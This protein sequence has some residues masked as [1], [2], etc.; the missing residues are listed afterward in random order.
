MRQYSTIFNLLLGSLFLLLNTACEREGEDLIPAT[1]PGKRIEFTVSE[2]EEDPLRTELAED[3]KTM[4]WTSGDR[5]GVFY[6]TQ[7]Q[8]GSN[9]VQK[10][11]IPYSLVETSEEGKVGRFSGDIAWVDVTGTHKFQLYYPYNEQ[12]TSS[13]AAYGT[14]P[15]EQEYSPTEWDLSKYAFMVSGTA[16]TTEKGSNPTI[17]LRHLFSILRLEFTNATGED[18]QIEKVTLTSTEGLILAGD[19]QANIGK[20]NTL[21]ALHNATEVSNTDGRFTSPSSSVS[22]LV[23]D[24]VVKAGE[25]I[26]IRLMIN[27]GLKEDSKDEYYLQ[28]AKLRVEVQTKGHPL[29]STEFT[30]GKLARGARAAK[31]LTIDGFDGS[32]PIITSITPDYDTNSERFY[33]N[34]LATISGENL[35]EIEGLT[36]GGISVPS[37]G[38]T[39]SDEMITFKIPDTVE[40]TSVTNCALVGTTGAGEEIA[41]GNIKVYPF[42][43]YKDVKLGLGS[44]SNKN[45][46]TY[47]SDNAFFLPDLG[48]VYSAQEWLDEQVDPFVLAAE[49]AGTTNAAST[50]AGAVTKNILNKE[51]ITAEEYYG[52]TPYLLFVADS[53][54]KLSTPTASNSD[55]V[56]RNHN[57][58]DENGKFTVLLANKIVGT[59]ILTFRTLADDDTWAQAV[60]KGTMESIASYNGKNPSSTAPAFGTTT[61]AGGTW[62]EDAVIMV[63]YCSYAKGSKSSNLTDLA[64]IGFFHIKEVTCGDPATGLAKE[65]R[66]GHICFDFYWSKAL[67]DTASIPL[68]GDDGTGTVPTPTPPTPPADREAGTFTIA[69]ASE[70][71]AL[72]PLK[73]GDEII[74]RSGTYTDQQLT[75]S[76][77]ETISQGIIFRAEN[78]GSVHFTGNSTLEVRTSKTTV[79]GFHWQDPVISQEHLIRFYTGTSAC[80]LEECA[81]TGDKTEASSDRSCKW[82]SLYGTGHT[83]TRCALLDKRDRGAQLVV[84][85]DEGVTPSHTISYNHFT[86]PT[87][88]V[89]GEDK[90]L[91]EQETLRVGDS[92]NSL[93]VGNCLV[94]GNYCY[95]C[96]GE[97]AEVISNKSCENIYR[98]NLLEECKGTLTL[99]Q[100]NDCLVEGNYFYGNSVA[101]SGGVR[102]IGEGHT[103]RQNHFEALTGIGHRASLALIRGQENASLSGYAQVKDA[104]IEENIFK[105]CVLAVHANYGS[106]TQVLPVISTTMKKNT[107][108]STST[109]NYAVRYETSTPEAEISWEDNTI[110][111]R[112]KNNYFS[113][114]S[115]KT[116][117]TLEDVSPKR[118]AIREAAGTTWSLN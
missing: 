116:V 87:V 25:K 102:I 93:S 10:R 82:L 83:V 103:V 4:L 67:N 56:L 117:P 15:V 53:G 40:F 80:R 32:A 22:T 63:G 35:G 108:V 20:S 106:G 86:R 58:Y 96:W 16:S 73:D 107:I 43:Y 2:G 18:L 81:I 30:G 5:L 85:F 104:L 33:L 38:F 52:I 65:T 57:T 94:E 75:L 79:R 70:L 46:T 109:S 90:A 105:E 31:A 13:S 8:G 23:T 111:G 100:G 78:N 59:P 74:W 48:E 7:P 9:T 77:E 84:W 36:V 51:N 27:A 1:D 118:A 44:N 39:V 89:D 11:N 101:D 29:W 37:Q 24:G 55:S 88:L 17:T 26:D 47:A 91:N 45:Y 6:T 12:V 69:S 54:H 113:L 21:E 64:K 110:Y 115:V 49:A 14:L 92:E 95:Q 97:S 62:T 72:L 60:K 76:S 114:T 66:E 99:R 41:L 34:T 71:N 50:R 28:G 61:S 3:G 98:G 112:F 19:F 42:F 68:Y